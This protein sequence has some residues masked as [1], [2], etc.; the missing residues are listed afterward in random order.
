MAFRPKNKDSIGNVIG[1]SVVLCLVC[2]AVV[3]VAAVS[4]RPM[5]LANEVL[6]KQRNRLIAA[7]LIEPDAP[8]DVVDRLYGERIRTQWIDL[9][10]GEPVPAPPTDSK[11]FDFEAAAD[12]EALSFDIPDPYQVPGRAPKAVPVYQ[13]LSEDGSRV[14]RLV[15]PVSGKGLW[16]TLR[17]YLAVDLNLDEASPRERFPIAGVTFYEQAETAGLG[18]EVQNANWQELWRDRYIYG[19]NPEEEWK[20]VFQVAKPAEKGAEGSEKAKY[21]VDALAGATIT[22]D[23]VED[24]IV[25]WLS[26]DAFGGYLRDLSPEKMSEFR[27]DPAVEKARLIEEAEEDGDTT[28]ESTAGE[29]AT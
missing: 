26:E 21:Q 23:G 19:P 24:M 14:E 25:Y 18:A 3:S 11:E 10:E 13:V 4:L 6:A 20:P 16:S 28:A 12:D 1:V 7:R 2:S 17:A 27:V 9:R 15:L 8:D 29:F 22:G 5:Q